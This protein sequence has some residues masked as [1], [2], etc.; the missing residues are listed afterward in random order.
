MRTN[1]AHSGEVGQTDS[2]G[3]VQN[4]LGWRTFT[5]NGRVLCPEQ[6]RDSKQI[7][8]IRCLQHTISVKD[9][10]NFEEHSKK[11]KGEDERVHSENSKT[12]KLSA[13]GAHPSCC[14][15]GKCFPPK[16]LKESV[17]LIECRS[18]DLHS[19]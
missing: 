17:S 2:T 19:C 12:R 16:T 10:M 13:R 7:K 4:S 5:Y 11:N 15:V 6:R 9:G 3:R 1:D 14:N 8:N 18:R